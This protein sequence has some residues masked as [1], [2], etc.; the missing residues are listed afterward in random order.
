MCVCVL[1]LWAWHFFLLRDLFF[2]CFASFYY[3]VIH[4]ILFHYIHELIWILCTPLIIFIFLGWSFL[5]SCILC[6]SWQKGGEIVENMWF[7]FKILHVRGRNTCLCKGEMCF[8]LLG[9]VL[10]S[11]FL[12]TG[13]VTMFVYIVLIFDIY[14]WWC[15][16]SSPTLTCV[17]SFLSLYTC[18]LLPM[19]A[20]Y[21]F[22]FTQ[23]C[24]DEFCLMCFKNTGCQSLLAIN[25]LLTKFFKSL[26]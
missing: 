21:Y 14:I 26:Y 13:L 23:R 25:S 12:Y 24:L 2:T 8:I 20:I 5:A 10:S 17:V 6:Q 7:L 4:S 11:I 19:Y 3:L 22:C 16:S 9:G 1:N 18:F 15:M